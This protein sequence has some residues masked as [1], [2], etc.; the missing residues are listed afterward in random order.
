MPNYTV[1]LTKKA[2]KQLDKIPDYIA[3]PIID[4]IGNLAEN[5]KPNGYKKLKGRI[6]YRIRTGDYRIIYDIIDNELIVEII[7]LGHRKDIYE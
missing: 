7:T 4:A 3:K 1:V 6:G 5:P 2:T